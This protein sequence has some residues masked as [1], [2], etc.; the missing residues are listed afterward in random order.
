MLSHKAEHV[1]VLKIKEKRDL[2]VVIYRTVP[3]EMHTDRGG[4]CL[5]YKTYNTYAYFSG[6]IWHYSS[7]QVHASFP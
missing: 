2:Q 5:P 1:K 3:Q 4:I 7:L 6:L